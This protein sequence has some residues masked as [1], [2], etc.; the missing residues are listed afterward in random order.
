MGW[1][2]D[3][4]RPMVDEIFKGINMKYDMI[5]PSS[6]EPRVYIQH[7]GEITSE[8]KRLI[9]ALFPDFVAVEFYNVKFSKMPEVVTK[10]VIEKSK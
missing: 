10:P 8:T 9:T 5:H 1:S 4:I 3:T 7:Q 2:L 6:V